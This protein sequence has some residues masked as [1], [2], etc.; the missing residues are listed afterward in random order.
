M[1]NPSASA[2]GVLLEVPGRGWWCTQ[3][4]QG[5]VLLQEEEGQ[6]YHQKANAEEFKMDWER[7]PWQTINIPCNQE[8]W[9]EIS[10]WWL[11]AHAMVNFR[12]IIYS[13]KFVF[14]QKGAL[15]NSII[16][17]FPF[18][19][20]KEFGMIHSLAFGASLALHLSRVIRTNQIVLCLPTSD[21]ST[22]MQL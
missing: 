11:I 20:F 6:V 18:A 7:I 16:V 1:D 9:H 8:S 3:A 21:L 4:S 12:L 10:V 13:I 5:L 22:H 17:A 15:G 14:P 2:G 19:V